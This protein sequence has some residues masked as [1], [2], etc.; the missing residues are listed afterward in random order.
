MVSAAEPGISGSEEWNA[1]IPTGDRPAGF[2]KNRIEALTD[3]IFAIALTLLVLGVEV[4]TVPEASISAAQLLIDLFPDF[5]HYILAFIVLA[6]IWVFHHQQFHHILHI[7]RKV[8]WLN[9]LG[10]MFITMVPFSSSYADT[11][12]TEQVSG[13]FFST[14]LLII[15]LLIW[16]QWE[17]ATKDHRLVSP[18]LDSSEIRFEKQ[19]NLII[20]TLGV[21]AITLSLFG[22]LWAAGIFYTLPLILF[23]VQRW[24]D[25]QIIPAAGTRP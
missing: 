13:I 20:P 1:T 16:L 22:V 24:H 11:Y 6:V 4:P 2:G 25:R 3:G 8:L 12:Y 14:N 15:G 19:K 5:F 21:L 7:D 9:I 18:H 23:L 10:L 17:H